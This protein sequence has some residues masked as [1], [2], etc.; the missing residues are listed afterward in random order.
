MPTAFHSAVLRGLEFLQAHPER[1]S[2]GRTFILKPATVFYWRGNC[3]TQAKA[4]QATC[5]VNI[6]GAT[7]L[8]FDT[9]EEYCAAETE[10]FTLMQELVF[11][12]MKHYSLSK[13]VDAVKAHLSQ[14]NVAPAAKQ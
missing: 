8:Q 1:F 12:Q 3:F 11:I 6:L 7:M 2:P 4:E 10:D 5:K 9:W 14:R 13:L